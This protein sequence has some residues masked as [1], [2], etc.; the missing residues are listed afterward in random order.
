MLDELVSEIKSRKGEIT[1]VISRAPKPEFPREALE[2]EATH[3]VRLPRS[4]SN[5]LPEVDAL[6]WRIVLQSSEHG[7][8]PLNLEIYDDIIIGRTQEYIVPDLDLT[9]YDA[10]ERGVSRQHALLHP[11]EDGLEVIDLLS[12]NG[13]FVNGVRLNKG[14]QRTLQDDDV[15]SFGL[16]HFKLTIVGRTGSPRAENEAG[17]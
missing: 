5:L 4:T 15:L 6:A 12:S 10:M 17:P 7:H 2:S 16:V 9:E 13:T 14:E 3:F 8:K 1:Q 11:T